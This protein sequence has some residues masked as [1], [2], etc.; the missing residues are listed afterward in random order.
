M[1]TVLTDSHFEIFKSLFTS[2]E[3]ELMR[4]K[5]CLFDYFMYN[6]LNEK[7]VISA[8]SRWVIKYQNLVLLIRHFVEKNCI[9]KFKQKYISEL[10]NLKH[11]KNPAEPLFKDYLFLLKMTV[12]WYIAKTKQ[13]KTCL[14]PREIFKNLKLLSGSKIYTQ[15]LL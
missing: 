7:I 15:I 3:P 10:Y 6:Y 2:P 13:I 11:V 14:K 1:A 9:F 12:L 4:I 5:C 8:N